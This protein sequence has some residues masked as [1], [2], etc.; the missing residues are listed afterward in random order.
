MTF[1]DHDTLS[2]MGA[3]YIIHIEKAVALITTFWS[4]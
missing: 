4:F 2:L 1:L 3:L